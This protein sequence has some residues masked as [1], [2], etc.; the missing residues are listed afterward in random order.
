MAVLAKFS[1][2]HGFE[3]WKN[4]LEKKLFL[5]VKTMIFQK[6]MCRDIRLEQKIGCRQKPDWFGKQYFMVLSAPCRIMWI[7][8]KTI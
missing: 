7:F 4:F 8:E 3:D 1:V 6:K 5:K 2:I